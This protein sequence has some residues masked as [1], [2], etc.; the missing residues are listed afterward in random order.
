MYTLYKIYVCKIY[1]VYYI[2]T[3]LYIKGDV[4]TLLHQNYL[5]DESRNKE[6][7]RDC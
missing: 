7:F 5:R 1:I 6:N 3:I 4:L 2:C